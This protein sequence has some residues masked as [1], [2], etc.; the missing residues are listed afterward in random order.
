MVDIIHLY[1]GPILILI[2]D[3]FDCEF[4]LHIGGQSYPVL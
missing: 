2:I 1:V 4:G 3:D